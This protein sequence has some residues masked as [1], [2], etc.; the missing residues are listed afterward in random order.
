MLY[1]SAPSRTSWRTLTAISV[2]FFF[3]KAPRG[4]PRQS[5]VHDGADDTLGATSNNFTT[6]LSLL[7][8]LCS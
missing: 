6:S 5:A 3:G 2:F 8:A 7:A 4:V 1:Q